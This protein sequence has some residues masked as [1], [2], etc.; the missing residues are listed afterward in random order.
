MLGPELQDA[1]D[2]PFRREVLRTLNR[3]GRARSVAELGAELPALRRAQLAYH[4]QVLRRLGAVAPGP[5]GPGAGRGHAHYASGVLEDEEVRAVLRATERVDRERREAAAAA[6]VS[7]LLAM[8]RV[9]RPVHT[10]RL[11]SRGNLEVEQDR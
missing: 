7:P 10:I 11:R 6:N 4:L 2:H 5:A 1:L 8:F 9:P 3:E